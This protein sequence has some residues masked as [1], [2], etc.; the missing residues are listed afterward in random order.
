M[1]YVLHLLS[2]F[3]TFS[4]TFDLSHRSAHCI[5]A[6]RCEKRKNCQPNL[7]PHLNFFAIHPCNW[8]GGRVLASWVV[9][10]TLLTAYQGDPSNYR[11]THDH[12]KQH[13]SPRAIA[14]AI[15]P[16]TD[17]VLLQNQQNKRSRRS[18]RNKS[19]V[20]RRRWRTAVK[21]PDAVALLARN[22][23]PAVTPE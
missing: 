19:I 13:P 21:D 14:G 9:L 3:H 20:P 5:A 16:P 22:R 4:L 2:P 18:K 12:S 10:F 17:F 8:K 23:V 6:A 15:L 7:T 11:Q 1:S